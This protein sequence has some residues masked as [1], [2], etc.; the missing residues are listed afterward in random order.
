[1]IFLI[2]NGSQQTSFKHARVRRRA[3]R[4]NEKALAE[5][6]ALLVFKK[7]SAEPVLIPTSSMDQGEVLCSRN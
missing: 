6:A 4:Q 2:F 5:A 1:M 3:A 7:K